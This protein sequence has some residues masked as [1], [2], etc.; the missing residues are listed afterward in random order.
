MSKIIDGKA[1]S[2]EIIQSIKKKIAQSDSCI[3]PKLVVITIG[4]DTASKVYVN[5]K[6]KACAKCGIQFHNECFPST[7]KYE[8]VIDYLDYLK[9]TFVSG[10]IIQLP[11]IADDPRFQSLSVWHEVDADGFET[12]LLAPNHKYQ[13]LPCTPKGIC[14]MIDNLELKEE[15]QFPS[16]N[17]VIIGRSSIVGKPLSLMLLERNFTVTICH[18]HTD[19]LSFYTKHA[20]LLISA[21]GKPHLIKT[22]IV[23]PGAVIID[24]GITRDENGK[25]CGDVDFN[26][27]KDIA[28]YITP[29][30]GGVGPMT[31]A[32]LMENTYNLWRKSMGS[33]EEQY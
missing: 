28:S 15:Y 17:A 3:A 27:V 7:V 12:N 5:N 9:H 1:L 6:A 22:D 25:L 13:S 18:S 29:V 11:I 21:T 10:V 8:T 30:P 14:K 4:D 2:E 16:R 20:D 24:V 23:K 32:M 33:E 31:V 26:E 19:D